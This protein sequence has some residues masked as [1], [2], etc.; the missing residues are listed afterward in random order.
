MEERNSTFLG[1]VRQCSET[2][3]LVCGLEDLPGEGT[4]AERGGVVLIRED[5]SRPHH[6]QP[7][8]DH[9]HT[10]RRGEGRTEWNQQIIHTRSDV[11]CGDNGQCL[12]PFSQFAL[13]V[14]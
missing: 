6:P 3:F 11:L 5:G 10:L 12:Q 14:Y 8:A 13:K 4:A 7:H 9:Q 1:V 2:C